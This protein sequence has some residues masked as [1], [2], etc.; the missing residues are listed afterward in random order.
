MMRLTKYLFILA[1]AIIFLNT[2]KAEASPL[3]D[4]RQDT[5]ILSVAKKVDKPKPLQPVQPLEYKL[6]E[7]PPIPGNTYYKCQCT[8]YAK[9]KRPDLP[10]HLGNADR[11]YQNLKARGWYVGDIPIKG[12]VVQFKD[13]MHVAFVEDV[14]DGEVLVSEWNYRGPCV[15]TRRWVP[16][17]S[18]YFI[19]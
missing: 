19:Y 7:R 3:L 5:S 6:P 8:Y 9:M 18:V 4:I 12:A 14:R 11:W 17:N 10:N 1:I 15:T 13:Y 16:T 2:D